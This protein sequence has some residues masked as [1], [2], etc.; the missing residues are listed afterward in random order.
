M[1]SVPTSYYR[2]LFSRFNIGLVSGQVTV[3]NCA[4][5]G[6]GI[7]IDYE[8]KNRYDLTVTAR[9]TD[10]TGQTVTSNLVIHINDVNDNK[11]LF[12]TKNYI[13]YI[14]ELKT[15]PN[16]NVLVIATDPDTVGG[17]ISYSLL[18]STGKWQ[19]NQVTGNVTA[20][21][22][23]LYTDA[24]GVNGSYVLY[25]IFNFSYHS[26][27]FHGLKP[28]QFNLEIIVFFPLKK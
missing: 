21:Q 27:S 13:S 23:I 3:A 16:P 22:P 20:K 4:T 8:R 25:F 6:S 28:N 5:P 24:P 14:E 2:L 10:G 26:S 12:A 17:P 15:V 7:C 9:D 11:P 19:M 18:D 1:V